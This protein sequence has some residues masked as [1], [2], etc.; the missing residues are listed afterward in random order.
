MSFELPD[1]VANCAVLGEGVWG[2]VYDLGEGTV[3]KLTWQSGGIGNPLQKLQREADVLQ[4]LGQLDHTQWC[5]PV[6][7]L[8]GHG[9]LPPTHPLRQAGY[10]GWLCS[11]QC[12]GE[13]YLL[14]GLENLPISQQQAM[15]EQAG[16]ALWTLHQALRAMP[17]AEALAPDPIVSELPSELSPEDKTLVEHVVAW[18]EKFP[19]AALQPI[20]GDYNISNLL[21]GTDATVTGIV[22]FAETCLGWPED[23]LA[24]LTTELPA[25]APALTAAYAANSRCFVDRNR[26]N[27]AA[28]KR[29]LIGMIIC[30][31]KLKRPEEA[32]GNEKTL[33]ALLAGIIG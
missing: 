26:L 8:V 6:P 1:S 27:C 23:D 33:C 28:A 9:E 10:T 14:A 20:H 3:L 25:W 2:R 18:Q 12:A 17:L 16:H 15:A 4:A 32:A 7:S 19:A 30:R 21:F 24:S 22:D 31:Y 5:L 11:T 13:T 29:A